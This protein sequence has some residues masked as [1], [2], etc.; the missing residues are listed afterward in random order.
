MALSL[1]SPLQFPKCRENIALLLSLA[2]RAQEGVRAGTTSSTLQMCKLR[3][4]KGR[5]SPEVPQL[6]FFPPHSAL[7][8]Y[9]L[10][11]GFF[12]SLTL[13]DARMKIRATY[14]VL[15]CRCQLG[16][17]TRTWVTCLASRIQRD[18]AEAHTRHGRQL[19]SL[20]LKLFLFISLW[21]CPDKSS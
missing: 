9:L 8:K 3:L 12:I 17:N 16:L 20:L 11:M 1:P 5:G 10:R 15:L 7:T 13:R 2:K 14:L 18:G 19:C 4:R 6:M 21:H